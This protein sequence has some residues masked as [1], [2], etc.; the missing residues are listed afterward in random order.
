[1]AA[2]ISAF[3]APLLK[4]SSCYDTAPCAGISVWVTAIFVFLFYTTNVI[5]VATL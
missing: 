3:F 4:Y 5:I 2:L 1:M